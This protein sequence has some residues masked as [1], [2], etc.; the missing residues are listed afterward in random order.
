MPSCRPDW[1]SDKTWYFVHINSRMNVYIWRKNSWQFNMYWPKR[2]AGRYR[3]KTLRLST[4]T[5]RAA[6][7]DSPVAGLSHCRDHTILLTN[8]RNSASKFCHM[9]HCA[10]PLPSAGFP[11]GNGKN[12]CCLQMFLWNC[13]G[14][15]SI[16]YINLQT[17]H[18]LQVWC[19]KACRYLMA[20][21]LVPFVGFVVCKPH[22][23][24]SFHWETKLS[25]LAQVL[26]FYPN[27]KKTLHLITS[28]D[29]ERRFVL[30]VISTGTNCRCDNLD[31][32]KLFPA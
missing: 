18:D 21:T 27:C 24:H 28:G 7:S 19:E 12:M 3:P 25:D 4:H 6:T 32:K 10:P 26:T 8:I 22:I 1:G 13:S 30:C 9:P 29:G 15:F 5:R 14:G 20:L 23:F 11:A 31:C 17:Q 16:F 2:E